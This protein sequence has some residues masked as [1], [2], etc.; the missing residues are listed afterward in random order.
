M[1]QASSLP[2]DDF[3]R[4]VDLL[5]R[6]MALRE[7]ID[8]LEKEFKQAKD[9]II[10]IAMENNVPGFRHGK[11]AVIV[12]SQARTSLSKEKL[13]ELGGSPGSD[14]RGYGGRR[15]ILHG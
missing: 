1:P 9:Q 11:T 3:E 7:D 13:L 14:C 5:E 8:R 10:V 12:G 2:E 4:A 15:G 6:S